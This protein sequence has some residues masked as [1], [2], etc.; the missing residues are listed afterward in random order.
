MEYYNCKVSHKNTEEQQKCLIPHHSF[1]LSWA[2]G[3]WKSW[4]FFGSEAESVG[5]LNKAELPIIT[6]V[7]H[8]ERDQEVDTWDK[9]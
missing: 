8:Q 3:S 4:F 6:G 2:K 5:S 9:N 7:Y 1:L